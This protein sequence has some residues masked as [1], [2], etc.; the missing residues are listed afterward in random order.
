MKLKEQVTGCNKLAVH[1]FSLSVFNRLKNISE[2]ESFLF[3]AQNRL[4]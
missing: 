1:A 2:D 4:T 3:E